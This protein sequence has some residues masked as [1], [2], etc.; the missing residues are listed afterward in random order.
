[1]PILTSTVIECQRS[2][3]KNS[4]FNFAAMLMRP[5]TRTQIDEKYRKKIEAIVRKPQKTE[6]EE[7][8]SPCPF[9][10]SPVEETTLECG[11]CQNSLPYCIATVSSLAYLQSFIFLV[12]AIS[13]IS[14]R[15]RHILLAGYLNLY[16][17]TVCTVH[18]FINSMMDLIS[19]TG[20]TYIIR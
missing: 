13:Y 2:G 4:S 15:N 7:P 14:N 6:E 1:M 9:C 16:L 12:L 10:S 3:L 11:Q 17:S 8:S 19:P 20:P 18:F 5:E